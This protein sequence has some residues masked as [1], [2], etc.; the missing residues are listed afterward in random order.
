MLEAGSGIADV[1]V[2]GD[3]TAVALSDET[4]GSVF[5]LDIGTWSMVNVTPCESPAGLVS[6]PGEDSRFWVGCLDG[7]VV[8]LDFESGAVSTQ[9]E[10]KAGE[11]TAI[12]FLPA[13]ASSATL[14]TV[15]GPT[16]FSGP[17]LDWKAVTI[18]SSAISSRSFTSLVV[19]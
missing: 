15:A 3:G 19:F 6:A 16:H 1:E 18:S 10:A 12:C 11:I 17:N 9:S 7:T 14:S 8:W 13:R 4:G 2:A 5:I